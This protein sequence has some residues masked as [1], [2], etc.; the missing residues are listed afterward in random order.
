MQIQALLKAWDASAKR[1][2]GKD[3]GDKKGK[4]KKNPF[5]F[6]GKKKQ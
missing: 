2:A 4:K 6:F 1:L 3:K 5:A